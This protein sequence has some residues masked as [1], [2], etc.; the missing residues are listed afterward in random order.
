MAYF[1]EG[2]AYL[3]HVGDSRAYL[4]RGGKVR[5]LTKDHSLVQELLD[6]GT[7]TIEEVETTLKNIITEPLELMRK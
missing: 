2:K 5:Q 7:I 1:H 4:I 3:G 6:N